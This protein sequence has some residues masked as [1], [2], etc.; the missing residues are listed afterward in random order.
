MKIAATATTA[1][2]THNAS[3]HINVIESHGGRS[4]HDPTDDPNMILPLLLLGA[5]A[6]FQLL[7]VGNTKFAIG[8]V[9]TFRVGQRD[10]NIPGRN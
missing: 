10:R 9:V 7:T 4:Q 3:I 8:S 1:C 6:A 5:D 2:P